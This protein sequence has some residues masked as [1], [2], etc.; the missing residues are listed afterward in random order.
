MFGGGGSETHYSQLVV[1]L[2]ASCGGDFYERGASMR[3]N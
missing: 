3:C 2:G 1:K